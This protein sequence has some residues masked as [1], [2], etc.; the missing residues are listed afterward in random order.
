[1][2]ELVPVLSAHRKRIVDAFGTPQ[3][4]AVA[5]AYGAGDDAPK[6]QLKTALEN[7]VAWARQLTDDAAVLGHLDAFVDEATKAASPSTGATA[8]LAMIFANATA[9]TGWWAAQYSTSTTYVADC[10]GCG[11]P[12]LRV[13]HFVCEYCGNPLYEET[14]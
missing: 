8:G 6:V 4:S 10:K 1:M 14:E 5:E 11:A 13:L 3:W 12:Q 9:N 2:K 7:V